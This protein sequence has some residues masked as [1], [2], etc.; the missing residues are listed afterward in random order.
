[1]NYLPYSGIKQEGNV[2][3]EDT[4]LLIMQ[5]LRIASDKDVG[6]VM[7]H[8]GIWTTGKSPRNQ[9]NRAMKELTD[10]GKLERGNGFYRI[11][12][13]KSEYADHARLLTASLVKILTLPHHAIIHREYTFPNG[14]RS[15][16][17]VLLKKE[18][19]GICFILEVCHTETHEYL[20]GKKNEWLRS[21][22]AKDELS[23]LFG[24]RVRSFGFVVE[25]KEVGWAVPLN[26]LIQK[27]TK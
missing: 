19:K 16:A 13:C 12:G 4:V 6:E 23:N 17:V 14:L 22:T 15:D 24:Y 11:P 7:A 27:E 5:Q 21:V 20:E 3:H 1:L 9:S 8:R 26:T 2:A 10:L 18:N 25:G